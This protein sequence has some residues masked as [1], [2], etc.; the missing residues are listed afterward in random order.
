MIYKNVLDLSFM[1]IIT[2]TVHLVLIN[3]QRSTPKRSSI[4]TTISYKYF[5]HLLNFKYNHNLQF[6]RINT[7]IV[8][9]D[10]R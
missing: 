9:M 5:T 3:K 6:Y 4:L 7:R 1:I 8:V 2:D 10:I